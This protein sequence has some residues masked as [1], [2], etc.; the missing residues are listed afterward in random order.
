MGCVT[1]MSWPPILIC[2][3]TGHLN[4]PKDSSEKRACTKRKGAE[5]SQREKIIKLIEDRDFYGLLLLAGKDRSIFRTL[6]SLSYDKES[7]I[8]WRA[9]EAIGIIAGERA[10]TDPGL[11]RNIVQRIL[12]M[13][14][15]ESGNN[16]WSA[17]EMLGEIVRNAPEDF[18]DIVPIIAS[19]H[20]EEMLTRGVLRAL[21]R[22]S[23]VRADLVGRASSLAG[24]YLGHR[25][26]VTRAYALKLAGNA[27][28]K[29]LLVSA[30][31]L[32][33]DDAVVRLYSDGDFESIALRKIA[34]ETVILLSPKGK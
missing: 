16:P 26:A 4:G 14:R 30:E 20:D 9:I 31:A 2:M 7:V 33:D 8:S 3:L 17:P 22:I 10:K 27:G 19:F 15:E 23:E 6:I 13:M 24:L 21:A 29:D 34:E 12:W 25:D 32:K 28:L 18:S 1:E 5:V 11:V